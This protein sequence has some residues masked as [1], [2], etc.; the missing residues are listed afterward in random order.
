MLDPIVDAS[1]IADL[2]TFNK[3]E[4]Q[5]PCDHDAISRRYDPA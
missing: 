5:R 3:Q 2:E 1:L 4:D